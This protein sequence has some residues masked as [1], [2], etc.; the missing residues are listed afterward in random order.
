MFNVYKMKKTVLYIS[1]F[2]YCNASMAQQLPLF[3]QYR[4]Y[5]SLLNP[6]AISSDFMLNTYKFSAGAS[7]RLQWLGATNNPKTQ[8]LR[9]EWVTTPENTFSFITGGYLMN[10]QTGRTGA[11][12]AYGRIA[13]YFSGNPKNEGFAAGLNI[14]AVQYRIDASESRLWDADDRLFGT[15]Q[16]QILPDV[17]VGVFGYRSL[18]N[19]EDNILYGGLSIP[20]VLGLDFPL[21]TDKGKGYAIKRIQHYYGQIGFYHFL[22]AESFIEVSSWLRYVKNVPFDADFNVRYQ[23]QEYIW[24]GAGFSTSKILHAEFGCLLGQLFELDNRDVKIGYGYDYSFSAIAPFF[25]A[26]HEINL[27]FLMR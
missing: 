16:Q 24:L 14:G 23:M 13:G 18:T 27:T 19:D 1:I 8:V 21:K 2:L 12:G 22:T 25:G 3:T 11:T 4:D 10:D 5:H 17:S 20:Q 7:M 9:A 6:A 26:S 15:R